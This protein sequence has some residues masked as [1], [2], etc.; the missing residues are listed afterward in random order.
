MNDG[1]QRAVQNLLEGRGGIDSQ[2]GE[3][4]GFLS[5]RTTLDLPAKGIWTSQ[6]SPKLVFFGWEAAWGRSFL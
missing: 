5:P 6:S 2:Y 3:L 1:Y 4:I